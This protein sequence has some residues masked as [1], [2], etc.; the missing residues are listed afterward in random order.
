MMSSDVY[1]LDTNVVSLIAPTKLRTASDEKLAEWI[2]SRSDRLWLS[3]I[4]A[5]EIE[6]GIAKAARVG[7]KRKAADLAEWWGEIRHYYASRILPLDIA[8]AQETGRL[9]DIA[10]AAGV[11]PGF[12]DVAIAATGK[13]NGLIVLTRNVKDFSPLGVMFKDPFE[14]LL[15]DKLQ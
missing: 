4:T 12:E 10:R 11:D 15:S 3:V 2:D 1:L 13:L 7:A 8:T 9:L 14:A 6:S 5:A